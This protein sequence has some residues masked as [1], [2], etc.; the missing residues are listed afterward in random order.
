MS[1]QVIKK[2]TIGFVCNSSSWGGLEMNV[3]RLAQWLRD[4]GWKLI[5]YG[6]RTSVL[7]RQAD[8]SG[9]PFSH[10]ASRFKFG[11][12]VNARRLV[13]MT[14]ADG[15]RIL[16][17]HQNRDILLT[18]LARILSRRFFKLVYMQHMQLGMAK[19]DLFHTWEYGKLDAW[20]AP[21]PGFRVSLREKTRLDPEKVHIIP[22]GIDTDRFAV[23]PASKAQARRELELP[24]K[25]AIAGVVGRLDPKKGQDVL[26]KACAG[27]HRAGINLHLLIVGDRT[28]GEAARYASELKE[29]TEQL[30]LTPYVH[31]RP[32]REEVEIVYGAMDVFV[33]PSQSETYGMVT[34]EAMAAGVPVIGTR[35]GGTRE[36]IDDGMNGLLF[37]PDDDEALAAALR[38][39]LEVRASAQ[40]RVQRAR[41]DVV[42][43]YSHTQ[44]RKLMES[45][46]RHLL[47]E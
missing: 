39:T 8:M 37:P 26:I 27:L 4:R 33:L 28:M 1:D 32:H 13:K 38:S 47:T 18:V 30:K 15:V 2:H 36:I 24:N 10:L 3:L 25:A 41:K 16:I 9:I 34:L 42:E 21:L 6:D 12:L 20:I 35:S 19:R 11:D 45:L 44:Q 17:V 46:F 5:I 23:S 31:F 14:A 40:K 7:A 22:F 43:K 29:L